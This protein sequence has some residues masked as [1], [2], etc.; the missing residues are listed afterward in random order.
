[1]AFSAATV[2]QNSAA[3]VASSSASCSGGLPALA[4]P[5]S[6]IS[7]KFRIAMDNIQVVTR[8]T[9]QLRAFMQNRI[10]ESEAQLKD[11][12]FKKRS[13]DFN[14]IIENLDSLSMQSCNV[15]KVCRIGER[16]VDGLEGTITQE[17]IEYCRT[18]LGPDFKEWEEKFKTFEKIQVNGCIIFAPQGYPIKISTIKAYRIAIQ[19]RAIL[20][21][22]RIQMR[23]IKDNEDQ[24]D[25]FDVHEVSEE[26]LV[27]DLK[28][29]CDFMR[30]NEAEAKF[31]ETFVT[32]VE[33]LIY[34]KRDNEDSSLCH[35]GM[36]HKSEVSASASASAAGI[37][38][39]PNK[40]Q[41]TSNEMAS[42]QT[43]G[44]SASATIKANVTQSARPNIPSDFPKKSLLELVQ[45][46]QKLS[47]EEFE[48][49]LATKSEEER[50]TELAQS[51]RG[52][53]VEMLFAFC[54]VD[55]FV[56]YVKQY[57]IKFA[58]DRNLPV[59]E[60]GYNLFQLMVHNERFNLMHFS[61]LTELLKSLLVDPER[62]YCLLNE[63]LNGRYTS[64]AIHIAVETEQG[65][66]VKALI[67]AGAYPLNLDC[68]G[69]TPLRTAVKCRKPPT[70]IQFLLKNYYIYEYARMLK[71]DQGLTPIDIAER[72]KG[73]D[74]GTAFTLL[75]NS[76]PDVCDK[77]DE[78][79]YLDV[80]VMILTSHRQR[81]L[82]KPKP[83]II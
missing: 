65:N 10:N 6:K 71:D 77:K 37:S 45:M 60:C 2:S 75:K 57:D 23:M 51:H 7:E 28:D 24:K 31:L 50:R 63:A 32:H 52:W 15:I 72:L 8:N 58:S 40:K 54:S 59:T 80:D 61:D 35:A 34:E 26:K 68:F 66:F 12:A 46:N 47:V 20:L 79:F 39:P 48:K 22:T 1:M 13:D 18:F 43:S 11:P 42:S 16:V 38:Q 69:G 81:Q 74:E 70:L 44:S 73:Y 25:V 76:G 3:S 53:S 55:L 49:F 83:S 29:F 27:A 30:R 78:T 4:I 21:E 33:G 14:K 9:K 56:H 36:K 5:I 82:R 41:K 62:D 64:A 17:Q 19:T 67:D